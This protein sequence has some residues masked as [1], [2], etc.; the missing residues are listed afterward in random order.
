[1]ERLE[2]IGNYDE[3]RVCRHCNGGIKKYAGLWGAFFDGVDDGLFDHLSYSKFWFVTEPYNVSEGKLKKFDQWLQTNG[4]ALFW[5]YPG[6]H[7]EDVT[8]LIVVPD[9][10][11]LFRERVDAVLDTKTRYDSGIAFGRSYSGRFDKAYVR[12]VINRFLPPKTRECMVEAVKYLTWMDVSYPVSEFS[13]NAE[14]NV[15][16]EW[17]KFLRKEELKAVEEVL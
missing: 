9:R 14:R 15:K 13:R 11:G 3:K 8:T 16:T 7:F 4:A 17:Y 1:M 10:L 5:V 2:R 6:Y 12:S